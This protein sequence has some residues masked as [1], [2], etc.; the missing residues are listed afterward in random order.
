MTADEMKTEIARLRKQNETLQ[1]LT[2]AARL[3]ATLLDRKRAAV[4]AASDVRSL[5]ASAIYARHNAAEKK[6]A[7]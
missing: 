3:N 4:K 2:D 5:D 7:A 1:S 6:F